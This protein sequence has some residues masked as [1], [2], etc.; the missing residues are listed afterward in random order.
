MDRH[1]FEASISKAWS[2]VEML[3]VAETFSNGGSLDVDEK[4]RNLVLRMD[5][6]YEDIFLY[7]LTNS[8]YNF[9]LT[10]H[11]FFQF[12]W[13]A[14]D[15]V[16]YA[17]YPNPFIGGGA[18]RLVR[19]KKNREL[20][21]S[22]F[23]SYEEFLR[24]LDDERGQGRV[25]VIRYENAPKQYKMLVH[26]CS[27]LHIGLHGEDRWAVRRLLNPLAFT[28]IVLRNY[29]GDDWKHYG[30]ENPK[31]GLNVLDEELI[32][33]RKECP[34]LTESYFSELENSAFHII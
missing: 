12:T 24:L 11:S 15:D 33:V 21:I 3:A 10:D 17:F 5:S 28:M 20:L 18:Q 32:Q 4:F 31:T 8:H 29:Y 2:K 27:H 30:A 23:I 34:L 9:L 13:N 19:Y 25:P 14:A 7:G 1:E 26:P 6:K 22:D 16:R